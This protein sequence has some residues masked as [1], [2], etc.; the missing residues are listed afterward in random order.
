MQ[1]FLDKFGLQ[2]EELIGLTTRET[3]PT[4]ENPKIQ[5]Y[6]PP[7][8]M[9]AE[10]VLKEFGKFGLQ[11]EDLILKVETPPMMEDQ[12]R[13]KTTPVGQKQNSQKRP[14]WRSGIHGRP[15]K[16]GQSNIKPAMKGPTALNQ[17]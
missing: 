10:K 2:P 15:I 12:E 17:V 9:L 16:E 1:K 7:H 13:T 14:S 6:T 3:P 4:T 8:Q 5:K 11:P